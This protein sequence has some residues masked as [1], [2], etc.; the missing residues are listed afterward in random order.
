LFVI[1][2]ESVHYVQYAI[3]AILIFSLVEHYFVALFL[4]FLVGVF[5]EAYQY[6]YLAPEGTAYYDFNDIITNLLGAAFGLLILRT[7]KIN[8]KQYQKSIFKI[9]F[10][11]PLIG[12][13]LLLMTLLQTN[14][15]SVYPSSKK[16][17]L[18]KKS[19]DSENFETGFGIWNDDG[20][21]CIRLANDL[22]FGN[23]GGWCVR[24]RNN[25]TSSSIT[26]SSMNFSS[27]DSLAISLSFIS[28][29]MARNDVFHVEVLTDKET[30]WKI[31]HTWKYHHDFVNGL[32]K[33][34]TITTKAPL[35]AN[36][37][38]RCAADSKRDRLY[39]DNI[40]ING[41]HIA[42]FYIVKPLEGLLII[43]ALFLFYYFCFS[44]KIAG[45]S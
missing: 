15:L 10:L 33:D 8:E 39:I 17:M 20:P 41:F 11:Y 24:L 35:T 43:S 19:G 38:I 2:I 28:K 16:Y 27:Y 40:D 37:R 21:D 34:A 18:I 3:G 44:S 45:M 14:L 36:F 9:G 23:S 30:Q 4:A 6:F 12:I 25:S 26:S 13:S 29:G 5:D 1:N 32:R 31:L 22:G 7:L 42:G